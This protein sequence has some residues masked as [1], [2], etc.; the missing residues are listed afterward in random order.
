[1]RW[2]GHLGPRGTIDAN[3]NGASGCDD[4]ILPHN[5]LAQRH[6]RLSQG[7]DVASHVEFVAKLPLAPK[8]DLYPRQEKPRSILAQTRKKVRPSDFGVRGIREIVHMTEH[9]GI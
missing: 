5:I 9:V 4:F 6:A 1:M 2:N 8:V 3:E 7:F